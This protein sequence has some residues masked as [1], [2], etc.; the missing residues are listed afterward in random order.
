ML[1][2]TAMS[3]G[4]YGRVAS[5]WGWGACASGD[6]ACRTRRV[7][8]T[9]W[10]NGACGAAS[11]V[12]I[13]APGCLALGAGA[14][15]AWGYGLLA[16]PG[17]PT[18]VRWRALVGRLGAW[19]RP[20]SGLPPWRGRALVGAGGTAIFS[21]AGLPRPGVVGRLW[22]L[23]VA[24]FGTGRRGVARDIRALALPIGSDDGSMSTFA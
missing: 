24:G 22:P 16:G 9:R 8:A 6:R 21:D 1:G 20:A 12:H 18:L 23:L 17:C 19:F 4:R 10:V 14:L 15:V 5:L 2:P 13:F 11:T 3:V 7:A